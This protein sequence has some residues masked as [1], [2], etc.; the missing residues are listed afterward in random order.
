MITTMKYI[1][2]HILNALQ[3][4]YSREA[5]V[6]ALAPHGGKPT[7]PPVAPTRNTQGTNYC[8]IEIY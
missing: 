3:I 4:Q 1:F 2:Q 7:A 8:S 6:A 5:V